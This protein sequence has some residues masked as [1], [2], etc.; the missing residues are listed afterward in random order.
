MLQNSSFLGSRLDSCEQKQQPWMNYGRKQGR[1]SW[2]WCLFSSKALFIETMVEV[3]SRVRG[4]LKV[5]ANG[6]NYLPEEWFRRE[7]EQSI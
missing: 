2:K 7:E 1:L 6:I 5:L 3:Q 4:G